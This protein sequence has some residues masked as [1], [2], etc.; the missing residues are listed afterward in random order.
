MPPECSME[1]GKEYDDMI[2]YAI[3]ISVSTSYSRYYNLA[4]S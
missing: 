3:V 1:K 2:G 4:L